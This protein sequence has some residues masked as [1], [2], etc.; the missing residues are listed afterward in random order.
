MSDS[1]Y[2]LRLEEPAKSVLTD[3]SSK[4][5]A[6]FIVVLEELETDPYMNIGGPNWRE[7]KSFVTLKNKGF[8]IR[9]LKARE[10]RDWRIFY[11][12]DNPTKTILVKEI[13]RREEDEITYKTGAHVKRLIDNYN[14]FRFGERKG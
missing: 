6:Y 9:F 12:I 10:I 2:T 14:R 13:V 8:P 4:Q 7:S 5:K 1:R 3:L 11:Y